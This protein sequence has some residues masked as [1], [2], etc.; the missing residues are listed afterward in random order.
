MEQ[1]TTNGSVMT[2][3]VSCVI[4]AIA[5]SSLLTHLFWHEE[6]GDNFMFS[7]F[8]NYHASPLLVM[9]VFLC[10]FCIVSGI[11][12]YLYKK[13][14]SLLIMFLAFLFLFLGIINFIVFVGRGG[15]VHPYYLSSYNKTKYMYLI[16]EERGY[17]YIDRV[18]GHKKGSVYGE[19]YFYIFEKEND[20]RRRYFYKTESNL[21]SREFKP[22]KRDDDNQGI[23]EDSYDVYIIDYDFDWDDNLSAGSSERNNRSSDYDES[24]DD[25][26]DVFYEM[27]DDD[28]TEREVIEQRRELRIV[29]KWQD[30]GGCGGTGSCGTCGGSGRNP[31]VLDRYED[32]PQCN[33]TRRCQFCGGSRGHYYE[34]FE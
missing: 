16:A 2:Y 10:I 33:G 7:F 21:T 6:L 20:G 4:P 23:I 26:E 1:K 3:I 12:F 11:F 29:Q 27:D 15:S 5:L 19:K 18:K 24:N 30:C 8:Y 17:D 22:L 25:E 34:T 31:F 13:T 9:F 32:C 14:K 28:E